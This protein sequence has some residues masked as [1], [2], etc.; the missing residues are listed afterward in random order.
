MAKN[1]SPKTLRGEG[2]SVDTSKVEA[3]LIGYNPAPYPN[4]GK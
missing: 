2:K 3:V 1:D 4:T